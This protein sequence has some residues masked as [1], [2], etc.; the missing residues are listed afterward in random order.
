M[1][2]AGSSFSPASD[3]AML[4]YHRVGK[5]LGLSSM[6]WPQAWMPHS[7]FNNP[8][9]SVV[10]PPHGQCRVGSFD[11]FRGFHQTEKGNVKPGMK[12]ENSPP[13]L[14]FK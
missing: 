8:T 14:P 10:F 12:N 5:G 4:T 1:D 6:Q 7:E 9:L 3:R 11:G 2:G 13:R